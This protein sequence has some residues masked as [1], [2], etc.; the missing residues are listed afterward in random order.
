MNATSLQSYQLNLSGRRA[1][2]VSKHGKERAIGWILR[3]RLG[4][5]LEVL[6]LDANRFPSFSNE[7][8]RP[9]SQRD[10]LHAK[11]MA[12]VEV[13][14]YDAVFVAS[15][16]AFV[17][18]PVNPSVSVNCELVGLYDRTSDICVVGSAM[19]E[20]SK[21]A[22]SIVTDELEL[23]AVLREAQFPSHAVIVRAANLVVAWGL[24]QRHDVLAA[25]GLAWR[26]GEAPTVESDVRARW[27][28]SRMRTI[29]EACADLA[30]RIQSR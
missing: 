16:G 10:R 24:T 18:D 6:Q 15:E 23:D 28:P 20:T 22:S 19:S 25:V 29:G 26:R 8:P 1:V 14:P 30:D 4:L 2:L 5:Y 17:P 27:N 9:S 13:T 12:A 7:V 3:E 21:R 11:L